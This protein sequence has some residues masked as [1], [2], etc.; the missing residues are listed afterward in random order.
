ME[1]RRNKMNAALV[2]RNCTDCLLWALDTA[3]MPETEKVAREPDLETALERQLEQ[4]ERS[5]GPNWKW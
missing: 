5:F 4:C 1:T 3:R 2:E